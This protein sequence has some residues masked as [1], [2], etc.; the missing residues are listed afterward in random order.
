VEGVEGT[1]Y[2][3][4]F[5]WDKPWG[6][7]VL[8]LCGDK[9]FYGHLKKWQAWISLGENSHEIQWWGEGK[10]RPSNTWVRRRVVDA[11]RV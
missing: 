11:P 1:L 4:K 7:A 6:Q 9:L 2:A 5:L 10:V 3:T 8:P